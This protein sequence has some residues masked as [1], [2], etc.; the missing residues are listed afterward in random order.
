MKGRGL[1]VRGASGRLLGRPLSPSRARARLQRNARAYG[2][3]AHGRGRHAASCRPSREGRRAPFPLGGRICQD[4]RG[5]GGPGL[6]AGR[7]AAAAF[8]SSRARA[9]S[10]PLMSRTVVAVA[11]GEGHLP[12][13]RLLPL[14]VLPVVPNGRSLALCA[15]WKKWPGG[16]DFEVRGRAG[17]H[18]HTR[19]RSQRAA[20]PVRATHSAARVRARR[21]PRVPYAPG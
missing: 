2:G 15:K 21:G 19:S 12:D 7:N 16:G 10:P 4:G 18:S 5:G 3:R 17:C 9:L 8:P 6:L 1:C 11:V 13:A 14:D 20:V